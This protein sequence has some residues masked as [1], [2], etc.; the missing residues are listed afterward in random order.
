MRLVATQREMSRLDGWKGDVEERQQRELT[1]RI[2]R[3]ESTARLLKG[4]P[5]HVTAPQ[6]PKPW[7][8]LARG[9]YRQPGEIVSPRGIACLTGVAPHWGLAEYAAEDDRRKALAEWITCS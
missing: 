5:V 6:Q 4:G 2:S 9:D 3:L 1:A 7:P 8:V